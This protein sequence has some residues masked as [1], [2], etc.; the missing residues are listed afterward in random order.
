MTDVKKGGARR[1]RAPFYRFPQNPHTPLLFVS[2]RWYN[3]AIGV[4][5]TTMKTT[6]KSLGHLAIAN[7]S[8]LTAV[9]G[10]R[11]FLLPFTLMVVLF[12]INIFSV[13]AQG[14]EPTAM[15]RQFTATSKGFDKL[16]NDELHK[17]L[18]VTYHAD[19]TTLDGK[20][21]L[22]G[23]K[24]ITVNKLTGERLT[25][26]EV[27][28]NAKHIFMYD[29][30]LFYIKDTVKLY[31]YDL[32]TSEN[33]FLLQANDRI[34]NFYNMPGNR[35]LVNARTGGL[36]SMP[37]A[38]TTGD[39]YRLAIYNYE[40]GVVTN[41]TNV[42]NIYQ[43]FSVGN[44]VVYLE[45]RFWFNTQ[46]GPVF[47]VSVYDMYTGNTYS[48]TDYNV[49]GSAN[50]TSDSTFVLRYEPAGGGPVVLSVVNVDKDIHDATFDAEPI[51]EGVSLYAPPI[52]A[53]ATDPY[54]PILHFVNNEAGV[55]YTKNLKTGQVN[56]RTDEEIWLMNLSTFTEKYVGTFK[57]A[58]TDRPIYGGVSIDGRFV[59]AGSI[60]LL[61]TKL[62]GETE[63]VSNI[64]IPGVKVYPN[65]ATT[66]FTSVDV[67][68][69]ADIEVYSALGQLTFSQRVFSNTQIP[70]STG[71]NIV[72]I[73]IGNL[74]QTVKVIG[75]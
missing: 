14:G 12:F 6:T 68:A 35:M 4:F 56:N 75:Y 37:N 52:A 53:G 57:D 72:K 27:L 3:V 73:T 58:L 22:P 54:S 11:N 49:L 15:L 50:P 34:I 36:I 45:S 21:L 38:V 13:N 32:T 16:F 33:K 17:M 19:V 25:G 71:V 30:K 10:Y 47:R 70:V 42:P 65:P 43:A 62:Y 67:P 46:T 44:K 59:S 51:L 18:I 61:T 64:T 66:G 9:K 7:T 48:H 8:K 2:N 24:V 28:R 74:T 55:Y 1:R 60:G 63:S 40:T 26:P 39:V 5:F 69:N 41:I 20:D 31:S 29:N 23:T